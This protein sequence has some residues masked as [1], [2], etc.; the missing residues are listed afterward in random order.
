MFTIK[1]DLTPALGQ[2][3]SIRQ[4]IS[5]LHYKHIGTAFHATLKLRA[6]LSWVEYIT[7]ISW[8][9]RLHEYLRTHRQIYNLNFD[10]AME[11]P[12]QHVGTQQVTLCPKMV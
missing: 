11:S 8:Y 5:L 6:I 10:K 9:K 12:Y 7:N 4:S 1:A 2:E 3:S